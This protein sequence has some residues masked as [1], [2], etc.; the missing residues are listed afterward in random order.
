MSTASPILRVDA[1][2][3]SYGHQGWFRRIHTKCAVKNVSFTVQTGETL[4]L[5]GESG[6]GKSSLSRA[7]VQLIRPESGQ[8]WLDV[9]QGPVDLAQAQGPQLRALRRHV[10]MM[11]QDPYASLDPRLTAGALV[12]EPLRCF[13][14]NKKEALRQARAR[15]QDVGLDADAADRYPHQFSGGQR[16]RIGLARALILNPALLILDEPVSALDVSVQVQ[17]LDL[18]REVKQR[19]GLTYIFISH[20][21]AVVRL[22]ADRVAVMQHG[23]IVESGAVDAIFDAPQHAYTQALLAA[24]P[25]PGRP[26]PWDR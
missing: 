7:L 15:L 8:V 2:T 5:V 12:A 3:V 26:A 17:M 1:L 11:F 6:C 18:L 25:D 13:G 9:G 20:D 21:L 19:L 23:T 14:V 24:V 4:G 22:L 16:Q 10:Q